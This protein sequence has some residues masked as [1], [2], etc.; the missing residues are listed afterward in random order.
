MSEMTP[1]HVQA[2]VKN[3]ERRLMEEFAE[4]RFFV[5]VY[6]VGEGQKRICVA[7]KNYPVEKSYREEFDIGEVDVEDIVDAVTLAIRVPP[8]AY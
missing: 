6:Y 1:D 7:V 4:P 2:M 3:L 8:A 5:S